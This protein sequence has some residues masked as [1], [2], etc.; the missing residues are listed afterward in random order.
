MGYDAV[1]VTV[2]LPTRYALKLGAKGR[3]V[4]PSELRRALGLK[5]GDKLV[6]TVTEKGTIE[7]RP[8]HKVA[9]EALGLLADLAPGTSLAD[10]LI[11]DRRKEAE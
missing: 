1:V 9:E 3:I 2:S 4:L 6:L 7:L 8:A 11:Q 5:P 10:E